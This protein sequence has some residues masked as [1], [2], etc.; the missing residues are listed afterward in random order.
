MALNSFRLFVSQIPTA[1]EQ[2][3]IRILQIVFDIM[4]VHEEELLGNAAVGVSPSWSPLI[5]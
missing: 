2:L 3:K 1:P 4:M 5:A